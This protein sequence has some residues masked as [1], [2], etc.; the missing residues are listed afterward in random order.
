MISCTMITPIRI[1][2][3]L[4]LIS[5]SFFAFAQKQVPPSI[6]AKGAVPELLA[7][8][9]TFTEGPAVDQAGNVYFTDQPNNRIWKYSTAGFLSVYMAGANRA[10]GLYIDAEDNILACA[11]LNN[12]LI[13][14]SPDKQ[15]SILVDKVAGKQLNGPNDLWLAPNGG[16]YF[17]DPYY[18]RRYWRNKQKDMEGEHV[19]YLSPDQKTVTC[20]A[21]GLVKPNGIIGTPDG[22]KL[23]VADIKADS[24]FA[25]DIMPD[26]SLTNQ[27]LLVAQGSDGM[28]LDRE[29]NIYLT[30]RK[31]V[32]VVNPSGQI[33]EEIPIDQKWTANVTFGG[34]KRKTLFITSMNAVYALKMRVKGVKP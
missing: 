30:G 32:T 9:F 15:V 22:L 16:I 5:Q 17:T 3:L 26:G 20:V 34:R 11:D 8:D 14:I 25:F 2:I 18:Q 6:V 27:G 24:T 10:N 29:G 7:D 28:T 1:G 23:Y 33:I 13:R 12:Q 21:K 19:Y 31:G 4:L